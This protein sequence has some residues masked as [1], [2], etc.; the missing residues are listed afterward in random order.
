MADRDIYIFGYGSIINDDSRAS[1]LRCSSRDYNSPEPLTHSIGG[2]GRNE[3]SNSK[4]TRKLHTELGDS[5][6]AVAAWLKADHGYVRS[7]CFH[8][9]T[10]INF[11]LLHF[12]FIVLPL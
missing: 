4:H 5:D 11:F 8:S 10:G 1:T 9:Q 7:W 3:S 12:I 6:E 2:K